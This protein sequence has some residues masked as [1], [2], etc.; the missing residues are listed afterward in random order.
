MRATLAP[1]QRG[2]VG[3]AT[4]RR[5]P[6]STATR[7][8]AAHANRRDLFLAGLGSAAVLNGLGGSVGSGSGAALAAASSAY[9][10]SLPQ[11]GTPVALAG[12]YAGKVTVLVNIA[13]A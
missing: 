12:R 1:H 4:N 10:F 5:S 13:S 8:V 7:N 11:Y 3:S 6:T 2:L 9:D